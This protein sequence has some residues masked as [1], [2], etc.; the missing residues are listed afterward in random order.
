[1]PVVEERIACVHCDTVVA[2]G[3]LEPGQRASCPR[4]GNLLTACVEDGLSRVL[5]LALASLMLLALANSFPFM[6]LEAQGLEKVMTLP[7]TARELYAQGYGVLAVLVLGVIVVIPAAMLAILVALTVSLLR[8]QA[9]PW[10][11]PAGRLLYA[12]SPW[13]MVEVFVIG[14][15]VSLVKIVHLAHVDLGI[16]F[17]SYTAFG[18]CFIATLAS[19]DRLSLWQEIEQCTS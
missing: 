13:S 17:W 5:A 3:P 10:L 18:I 6:A 16:A 15:I 19:L 8:G 4:C 11:V 12:M 9:A 14:V 1:V 2:I 7:A